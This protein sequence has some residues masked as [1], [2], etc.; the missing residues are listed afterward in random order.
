MQMGNFWMGCLGERTVNLVP[1][2]ISLVGKFSPVIGSALGTPVAG[3]LMTVIAH[4]FKANP[5]DIKDIIEK[6]KADPEAELKIK[7][8]EAMVTDLQSARNREVAFTDATKKRDW[9]LPVLSL[10]VAVGFF[11]TVWLIILMDFEASDKYIM[12]GLILAIGVQFAQVYNY[13][14]GR[15][16]EDIINTLSAPF[17]KFYTTLFKK[18]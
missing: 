7:S 1:D 14:F 5:T 3:A 9:M 12:Y 6:L 8:M 16:N 13:Y 2:L 18:P 15:F 10:L 17:V 11:V 4:V